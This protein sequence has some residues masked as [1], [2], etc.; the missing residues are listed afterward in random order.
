MMTLN[1]APDSHAR[2][3]VLMNKA[4]AL[5]PLA[6]LA[7]CGADSTR[8]GDTQPTLAYPVAA[9]VAQV[10]DYYGTRVADPYRWFEQTGDPKVREWITAENA[11]AQPYLEGIAARETIKKRM[12]ELWNYERYDLPVR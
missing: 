8:H 12:T 5:A 11:L 6:L 4:L 3:E 10:D 2:L 1:Y 9:R 7:A